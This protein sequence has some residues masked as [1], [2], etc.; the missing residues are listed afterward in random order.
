V[1]LF[2]ASVIALVIGCAVNT[3]IVSTGRNT[4]MV[5]RQAATGFSGSGNLM[6]EALREA[7]GYC[8]TQKRTL[9]VI[10]SKEARPPFIFGNFPKAEVHFS[11][12]D[13]NDTGA[14]N[15]DGHVEDR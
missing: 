9:K 4:Y 13:P 10:S 6:A 12:I 14:G 11:C 2:L 15:A 3:G 7:D 5:A 8:S 1:K